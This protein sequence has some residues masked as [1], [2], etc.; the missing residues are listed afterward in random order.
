MAT[1]TQ[2][3]STSRPTTDAYA[4][5]GSCRGR[6]ASTIAASADQPRLHELVDLLD[7]AVDRNAQ[8]QDQVALLLDAGRHEQGFL[9][10]ETGRAGIGNVIAYHLQTNLHGLQRVAAHLNRA[11]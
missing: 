4:A 2:L 9:P 11:E 7:D 8:T 1:A 6:S 3:V 5:A 10:D